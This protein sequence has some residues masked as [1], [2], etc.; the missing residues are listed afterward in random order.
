MRYESH[1]L[2]VLPS[3]CL[4][5]PVFSSLPESEKRAPAKP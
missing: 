5:G 4:T 1:H 2:A 3:Q